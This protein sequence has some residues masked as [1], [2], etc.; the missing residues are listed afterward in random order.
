[1]ENLKKED[2]TQND[3]SDF[4]KFEMDYITDLKNLKVDYAY[5]VYS[6]EMKMQEYRKY[7]KKIKTKLGIV[8]KKRIINSETGTFAT[9][10][11]K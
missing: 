7:I 2:S 4:S 3:K 6:S 8:D 11:F 1:M 10:L 9:N 5:S